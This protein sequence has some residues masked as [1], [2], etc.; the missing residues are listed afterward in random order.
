[1][2]QILVTL[3]LGLLS[4]SMLSA[5]D[6]SMPKPSPEAKVEQQFS[7]S[8]IKYQYSRPS[9][10]GRKVFGGLVAMN[11]PWR[12][13]ANGA[14]KVT[15]G[16]DVQIEGVNLAAGTYSFYTIPGERSWE[17]IFN[18]G[19]EN[20][21]LSGYD[22]KEDALRVRVVPI[23]LDM[24]VETFTIELKD[25]T[26]TSAVLALMWE[27]TYV[28]IRITADNKDRILEH[29]KAGLA[30]DK[31]PYYQAA[32]YYLEQGYQL[33]DALI[34]VNK[35][36]DENKEAFWLQWLK[37]KIYAKMGN[38]AKAIEAASVAAKMAKGSEYEAEY[39]RN[40]DQL[41]ADL[42]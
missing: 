11:D 40:L 34:Y 9:M 28:P 18:K 33:N 37:A 16:E 38:N 31:P 27:K 19:L 17:I 6:F 5:Q 25:I 29:L 23:A 15:F 8:F 22:E 26:N 7:T 14:T 1:M 41:K 4:H 24:P 30:G 3:A 12:T 32:S 21:G 2:K 35:A 39:Q 20:W 42:K 13:G 36:I 10:K